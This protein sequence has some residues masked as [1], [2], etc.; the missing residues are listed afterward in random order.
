MKTIK[1]YV[2]FVLLIPFVYLACKTNYENTSSNYQE[3]IPFAPNNGLIPTDY[4]GPI[5]QANYNYPTSIPPRNYPWEIVTQGQPISKSTAADY[6]MAVRDYIADDMRI[7][8]NEPDQWL[9]SENKNN[10]YNMGWSGQSYDSL[11]YDGLESLYGTLTGQIV[12]N[13]IF[14]DYGFE[15]PLQN[16]A[17]VYYNDVAA[18]TLNKLWKSKSATG[19]FPDYTT[20]AAQFEQNAIIIKAA[21][22]TATPEEWSVLEGA[23]TFKVYRPLPFGPDST[24]Q[25]IIQ[26]L[27]WIQF[28]IIV[29]DTIASPETGW[30]FSTFIYD[31]NSPG[32][33][34][35]DRLTLLGVAWG[36][37]PGKNVGSEELEETYLNP[38]AP[39]YYKAN[40][41]HGGRL[42][43]PI[44]IATVG[45]ITD[46]GKADSILVLNPIGGV[47]GA[48]KFL[49]FSASACLSCHST[50]SWPAQND[51]YPSPN[52]R[53]LLV[54]SDTLYNPASDGWSNYYQNRNGQQIMR[55]MEGYNK[56]SMALDYD[57]FMQFALNNSLLGQENLP[58]GIEI[59][60]GYKLWETNDHGPQ[61]IL[62]SK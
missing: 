17:L 47:E 56:S 1:P 49:H 33:T 20:E 36:N 2:V 14:K 50:A 59:P 54:F 42:S 7:M 10:W 40:I 24:S 31:A 23:G 38:D 5:F 13:D 37:D 32:S 51:F 53:H 52:P 27:T 9:V 61:R 45:G 15:G 44:D 46:K 28:D 21:G 55:N 39:E 43:G 29:K 16:H 60:E 34:T 48:Q 41:G 22:A 26:E 12:K 19:F 62:R 58:E 25:P 3:L 4:D 11:H 8:I 30:V 35:F 57:L 6:I 18:L